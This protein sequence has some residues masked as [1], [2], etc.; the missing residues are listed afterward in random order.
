M[1]AE[2]RAQ[3][4]TVYWIGGG[5]GAGKSTTARRL[6]AQYGMSVYATDDVMR[7]H[8]RRSTPAD[9][10][11]LSR[12]MEMD[13]DER[14]LNR[15]PQ[16]MLDT[17]HWYRGEGFSLIVEDL[18]RMPA[19][20]GVIA[21]GFR[22]LPRLVAPL[23]GDATRAVWLLPTAR[24]R[25]AAFESRGSAWDI[26]RTTSDPER[27]QANLLERDGMFTDRLAAE[28]KELRLPAIEVDVMMSEDELTRRV[29]DMF[30]L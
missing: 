15:S 8:A 1:S 5:S 7:E 27:A 10:P 17:F 6:A 30:G 13:M 2:L 28:A 3:L 25:W 20:T 9:A 24:F 22:L 18:L 26:P 16:S 11:Q 4:G 12:F 14:W 19:E 23:L 21:E 29:A